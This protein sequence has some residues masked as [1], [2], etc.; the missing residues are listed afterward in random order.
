MAVTTGSA[1]SV[2]AAANAQVASS[3][4]KMA[5]NSQTFLTLLTTQ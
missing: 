2:A 3:T 4:K 1:A 5:A